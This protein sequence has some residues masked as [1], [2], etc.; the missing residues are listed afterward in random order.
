[1]RRGLAWE[2]VTLLTSPEVQRLIVIARTGMPVLKTM[3]SDAVE[4]G[5]QP[6][7]NMQAFIKGAGFGIYP[8]AYPTQC[9]N[10][11]SGLVQSALSEAVRDVIQTGTEVED[12]FKKADA[13]IQA[14]LDS[15]K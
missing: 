14:C 1:V 8:S 6:P 9:G 7:A 4:A 13:K 5:N 10:Y 11:Y 3:G 12:A 15:G 2:F